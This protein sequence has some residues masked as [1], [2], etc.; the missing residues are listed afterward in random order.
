MQVKVWQAFSSNHS[1]PFTLVGV[2]NSPV[3]AEAAAERLLRLLG[4]IVVWRVSA[5]QRQPDGAWEWESFSPTPPE[6]AA[7]VELGI[8]WGPVALDWGWIDPA[9]VPPITAHEHLLFVDGSDS[10][11]G[12]YLA[13]RLVAALGG[14]AMIDGYVW[15]DPTMPGALATWRLR[16][17]AQV[18][19]PT[20]GRQLVHAA[21]L[22]WRDV[23][24][25]L[26]QLG[27]GQVN[28]ELNG[29]RGWASDLIALRD[30]WQQRGGHAITYSFSDIRSTVD[31][32]E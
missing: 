24:A 7:G 8:N 6:V 4:D 19:E 25:D 1:A 28:V 5:G 21:K 15:Q 32:E 12:A 2:F 13:E 20:T 26:S 3:E 10:S 27:E 16:L 29:F 18:D 17:S 14:Q 23:T 9:H 11:N 31:G 30:Y 22:H